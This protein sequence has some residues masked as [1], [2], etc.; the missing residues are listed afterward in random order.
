MCLRR[1]RRGQFIWPQVD[2]ACWQ[3]RAEH[4]VAILLAIFIWPK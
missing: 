2:N 1:L 3:K 4:V